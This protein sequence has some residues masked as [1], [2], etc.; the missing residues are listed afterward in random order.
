MGTDKVSEQLNLFES[1]KPQNQPRSQ[2]LVMSRS[3]LV[4]WKRKIYDYQ[5]SLRNNPPPQQQSLFP[6]RQK[7]WDA[8]QNPLEPDPSKR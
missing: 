7:P 5:Q 2:D 6:D 4:Q 8:D 3:A 1:I